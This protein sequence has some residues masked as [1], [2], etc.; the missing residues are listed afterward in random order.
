MQPSAK[1]SSSR[2]P[3]VFLLDGDILNEIF[4]ACVAL[5]ISESLTDSLTDVSRAPWVLGQ[6]CQSWRT[7]VLSSPLLW[8]FIGI[9]MDKSH[10]SER[11]MLFLLNTYLCRSASCGLDVQLHSELCFQKSPPF[12]FPLCILP[13]ALTRYQ[14][15]LILLSTPYTAPQAGQDFYNL[16]EEVRIF[17]CCTNLKRIS[18]GDLSFPR[19]VFHLPWAVIQHLDFHI[20]SSSLACNLGIF[21]SLKGLQNLTSCVLECRAAAHQNREADRLILPLLHSMTLISV[22]RTNND[23]TLDTETVEST[24]G[25]AQILSW[26]TLPALQHLELKLKLPEETEA[27]LREV[28]QLVYRSRCV[29]GKFFMSPSI[30]DSTDIMLIFGR[31]S[32]PSQDNLSMEKLNL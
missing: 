28:L 2:T 26:L 3:K 4:R 12:L 15:S 29:I 30:S 20:S 25:V 9:R 16:A 17:R 27:S 23:Q 21:R 19:D 10:C 14:H 18:L 24:T 11:R 5:E 7:V 22:D 8:R 32:D 13:L 31:V 1:I 6:V